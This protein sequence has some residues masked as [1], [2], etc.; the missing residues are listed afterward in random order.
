MSGNRLPD[1][2]PRSSP[3]VTAFLVALTIAGL[4]VTVVGGAYALLANSPANRQDNPLAGVAVAIGA[5]IAVLGGIAT[6]LCMTALVVRLRRR[7]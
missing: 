1:R 2:P 3:L 4:A 7:R 6:I 5:W